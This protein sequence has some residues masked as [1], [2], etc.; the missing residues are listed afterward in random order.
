M[1]A[2]VALQAFAQAPRLSP[3]F[4]GLIAGQVD[5]ILGEPNDFAV[6]DVFQRHP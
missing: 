6:A 4:I 5:P 1:L 2:Q 3:I